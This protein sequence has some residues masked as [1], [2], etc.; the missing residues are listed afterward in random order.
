MP[1][2]D[3][4]G[5]EF[6]TDASLA[7]HVGDK[8][9]GP[10]PKSSPEREQVR[11]PKVARKSVRRRNSRTRTYALL[12]VIVAVGVGVYFFVSPAVAGPPFACITEGSYIHIHPYVQIVV[13]GANVT[14]PSQVGIT[15]AGTCLEPVHTHDSS[16]ILHLELSQSD[17]GHNW[18]LGDFF[19]IWKYTCSVQASDCPVVNGQTRPVVFNQTD[20]LGFR[21][22]STHAVQ[23]LI[24][25]TANN[26]W[27][28][29]PLLHYAFCTASRSGRLPCGG[30]TGTA[31]GDPA[32]DCVAAGQCGTYPYKTGNIIRIV[33]TTA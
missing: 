22:D 31:A 29:L 11:Q 27:G 26:S 14:I 8:H 9:G 7:Q 28:S 1:K 16:G 23:L 10:E 21:S 20:I 33:Y 19:T 2:C 18:T 6:S 4:C 3:Q 32:W 25:G 30:P 13:N 12:A 17:L 15:Q 5:R 24:N